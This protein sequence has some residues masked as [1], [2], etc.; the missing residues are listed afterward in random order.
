MPT[1]PRG[2]CRVCTPQGCGEFALYQMTLPDR[3]LQDNSQDSLCHC[4]H[5]YSVHLY[6]TAMPPKAGC[7]QS[8]CLIY[9]PQAQAVSPLEFVIE[10][11]PVIE[12]QYRCRRPSLLMHSHP[13]YADKFGSV[14]SRE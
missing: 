11:L 13:A 2:L 10:L 3:I 12:S 6:Q 8:S 5:T 1:M 9:V 4:Q 14:T 7:R